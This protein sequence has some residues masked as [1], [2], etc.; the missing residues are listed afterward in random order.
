LFTLA[1]E[2]TTGARKG[3]HFTSDSQLRRT[4]GAEA[5]LKYTIAKS[6]PAAQ[7]RKATTKPKSA[8]GKNVSTEP[9]IDA[10]RPKVR[11]LT[12]KCHR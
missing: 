4:E 1:T 11:S 3:V 8:K 2:H 9:Q 10:G 12:E 5:S 7:K 6:E